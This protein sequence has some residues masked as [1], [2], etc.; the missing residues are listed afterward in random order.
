MEHCILSIKDG[1]ALC[2]DLISTD[3]FGPS[4]QISPR[5]LQHFPIYHAKYFLS[6]NAW[7]K[8][9]SFNPRL[10]CLNDWLSHTSVD[11]CTHVGTTGLSEMQSAQSTCFVRCQPQIPT[12]VVNQSLKTT[13]LRYDRAL[14]RGHSFHNKILLSCT[15][16]NDTVINKYVGQ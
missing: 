5:F 8:G 15:Q 12:L 7:K 2:F 10:R 9:G 11:Q 3:L 6:L 4:K 14:R 13:C 1:Q 16:Y